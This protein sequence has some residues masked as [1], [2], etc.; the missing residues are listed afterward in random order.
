MD[1]K[2]AYRIQASNKHIVTH[3]LQRLRGGQCYGCIG[4]REEEV[5]VY[6]LLLGCM[7]WTLLS[8]CLP[9]ARYSRESIR[10]PI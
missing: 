5:R 3:K 1:K 10:E 7:V 8:P 9:S 2:K 6:S 4:S